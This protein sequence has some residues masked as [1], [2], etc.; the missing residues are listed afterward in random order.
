MTLQSTDVSLAQIDTDE[1][2][3]NL[4]KAYSDAAR[5]AATNATDGLGLITLNN[6]GTVTQDHIDRATTQVVNANTA[7]TDAETAYADASDATGAEL[8]TLAT[9]TAKV[10][11]D[12]AVAAANAVAAIALEL[13]NTTH[14]YC[15]YC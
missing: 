13:G 2:H 14:I 1:R 3:L 8:V 10:A 5:N 9:V 12:A 7:A 11:Y 4:T 6:T 15:R